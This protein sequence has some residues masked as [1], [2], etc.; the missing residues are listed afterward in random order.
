M[1][2]GNNKIFTCCRCKKVLKYKPIRLVKQ[3]YDGK[4]TYGR[5]WNIHNYDFC[6][7]CYAIFDNWVRKFEVKNERL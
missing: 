5:Y 3:E 2:K 7:K 1:G 6:P 4:E